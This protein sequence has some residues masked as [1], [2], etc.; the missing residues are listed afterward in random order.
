MAA[1]DTFPKLLEENARTRPNRPAIRE[2]DLG[3]WQTWNWRQVRDEV[4]R[5][6]CGLS[7]LGVKS[8][9]KVAIIGDNRPRLYWS[10]VA[11][12]ALGAI[13]SADVSGRGRQRDGIRARARGDPLRDRRRS[14]ADRQAARGHGALP[15]NQENR[16][17]R[18]ARDA[19]LH[20][21]LFTQPRQT[22]GN[23][24]RARQGQARL[25][26]QGDRQSQRLG[27]RDHS[28]Y[29]RYDRSAQGRDADLRQLGHH[30]GA[31]GRAGRPARG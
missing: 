4:R 18:L 28:L 16:L 24:R 15:Q 26:R 2:K 7:A 14:R 12:Q 22:R 23:G 19:P 10:I 6:A 13:P 31:F 9:D 27:R 5:I 11:C 20:P 17:Q 8:G 1:A 3:I 25:L 30:G 21:R 29:I